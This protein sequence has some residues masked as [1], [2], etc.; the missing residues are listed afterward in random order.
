[1]KKVPSVVVS[2]VCLNSF[3][4]TEFWSVGSFNVLSNAT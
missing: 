4:D 3:A 2:L 1:M